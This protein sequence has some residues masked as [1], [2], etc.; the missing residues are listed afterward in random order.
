MTD[1]REEGFPA[2]TG[3]LGTGPYPRLIAS[4]AIQLITT[5]LNTA[6]I[7][8]QHLII[9]GRMGRPRFPA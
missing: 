2:M 3:D 5:T 9:H 8:M 4:M 6:A 1:P 7:T